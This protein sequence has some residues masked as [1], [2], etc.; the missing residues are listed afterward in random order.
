MNAYIY[1]DI[2][3]YISVKLTKSWYSS[4]LGRTEIRAFIPVVIRAVI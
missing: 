2:Y 3:T 4:Y 1:M